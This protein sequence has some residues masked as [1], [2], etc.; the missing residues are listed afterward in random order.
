MGILMKQ[1]DEIT[2]RG[3]ILS[4][5]KSAIQGQIRF[6]I[7]FGDSPRAEEFI[8]QPLEIQDEAGEPKLVLDELVPHHGV[9]MAKRRGRLRCTY[10]LEKQLHLFEADLID[11]S[12]EPYVSLRIALPEV[13]IPN[14]QRRF[15]RIEP[16]MHAPVQLTALILPDLDQEPADLAK[17]CVVFD[18]SLGGI[19]FNTEIPRA[20]LEVGTRI[21]R[22]DFQLPRGPIIT[23]Q[24][25]IRSVRSNSGRF[26]HRIGTEFFM[27]DK[28]TRETLN[29]YIVNK[30]R[31]DIIKIKRE[32]E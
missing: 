30:Q 22:L 1:L 15:F 25:I 23:A 2:G 14:Q 29:R 20:Q 24:A 21:P 7:T 5:L 19:S 17:R 27:M 26:R 12:T 10:R 3:P 16:Y 9:L 31:T 28:V 6:A 13:I 18:L 4:H 11:I 32:L 8:S